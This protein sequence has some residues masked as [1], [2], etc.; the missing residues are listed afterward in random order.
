VT[1]TKTWSK[2]KEKDQGRRDTK[3]AGQ[4][5]LVDQCTAKDPDQQSGSDGSELK[6]LDTIKEIKGASDPMTSVK[7]KE[8][9]QNIQ[10]CGVFLMQVLLDAALLYRHRHKLDWMATTPRMFLH[11]SAA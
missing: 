8:L 5:D 11:E 2:T 9:K 6:C 1:A 7:L 4:I 10:P 3:L